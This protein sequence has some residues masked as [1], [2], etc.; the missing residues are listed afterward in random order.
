M[1]DTITLAWGTP[2]I[3]ALA[4]SDTNKAWK[5]FPTP[6][7]GTTTLNVTQGEKMEAKIEG[8]TNEA[9]KYKANTYQLVFNIR[10][11]N[12]RTV[13]D[14]FIKDKD[15]VVEGEYAIR[16]TPENSAAVHALIRRASVNVQLNYTPADGWTKIYTF[17]ALKPTDAEDGTY[18]PQ[19]AIGA[20]ASITDWNMGVTAAA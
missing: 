13:M 14:D 10:Q 20:K 4:L 9:V 1:A 2:L 19:V 6:A 8:G 7:E 15:G 3:E 11:A 17:D 16:I 18:V 12:D 5:K